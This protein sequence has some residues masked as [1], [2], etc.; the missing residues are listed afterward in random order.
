[1]DFDSLSFLQADVQQGCLEMV[2]FRPFHALIST[3]ND[4]HR[5]T[6]FL[7]N[8]NVFRS[9]IKIFRLGHF[10]DS[11]QVKPELQTEEAFSFQ[12]HFLVQDTA[13]GCH[14]LAGTW[15]DQTFVSQAI[16][17]RQ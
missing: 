10:F 12:G 1:M 11:W 2:W 14:P 6:G 3:R 9:D 13:P 15:C 7:N 8:A 17:M 4:P 5:R 16:L